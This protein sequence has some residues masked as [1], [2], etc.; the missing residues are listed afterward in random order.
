MTIDSL[1]PLFHAP[2]LSSLCLAG[3]DQPWAVQCESQSLAPGRGPSS[4]AHCLPNPSDAAAVDDGPLVH[5]HHTAKGSR[6]PAL[7]HAAPVTE[8]HH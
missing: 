6:V 7:Q 5:S 2:S 3:R 4:L 8:G 1:S